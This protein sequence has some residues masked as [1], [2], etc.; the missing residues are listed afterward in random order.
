MS[1]ISTI[2]PIREITS[3][4]N[5]DTRPSSYD[6]SDHILTSTNLS[7]AGTLSFRDLKYTLYDTR[8]DDQ[9]RKYCPSCLKSPAPKRILHKV[10]G[11][12]SSG[13]NAILGK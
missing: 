3:D 12:F 10:S 9:R 7:S 4:K 2:I 11:I 5:H 6:Q 1:T 13:M 8:T